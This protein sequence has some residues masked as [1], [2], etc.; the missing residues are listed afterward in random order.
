VHLHKVLA[1]S[2][3]MIPQML[4]STLVQGILH[5]EFIPTGQNVNQHLYSD[6]PRRL[7]EAVRRILPEKWLTGYWFL[8]NDYAATHYALYAG[9]CGP[10]RHDCCTTP[11]LLPSSDTPNFF[12]LS[13]TQIGTEG[14]T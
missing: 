4:Q 11:S 13:K 8:H 7:R 6:A 10:K 14:N 1:R 5:Y 3:K 12:S 9:I 2:N